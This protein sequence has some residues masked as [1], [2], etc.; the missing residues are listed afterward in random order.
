MPVCPVCGYT[1]LQEPPRSASGGG[2][3]EICPSCAFQFGVDDDDKE[4]TFAEARK[5]WIAGGMKWSSR[6]QPAPEDWSAEVQL[7]KLMAGLKSTAVKKTATKKR[8]R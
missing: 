5:R 7:A 6:G 4:I 3:Y 2:S 1:K 8:S